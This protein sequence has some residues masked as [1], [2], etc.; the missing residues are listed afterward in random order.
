MVGLHARTKVIDNEHQSSFREFVY[1]YGAGSPKEG[2]SL[3]NPSFRPK[4][5]NGA[6]VM[7]CQE[8]H[9]RVERQGFAQQQAKIGYCCT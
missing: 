1:L 5:D 2:T 3:C 4:R 6:F 7:P 9:H 8:E